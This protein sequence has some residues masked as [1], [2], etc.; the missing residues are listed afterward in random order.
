[1]KCRLVLA[2]AAFMAAAVAANIHLDPSRD[3]VR[4]RLDIP[5]Q[6][7]LDSGDNGRKS[8]ATGEPKQRQTLKR[9]WGIPDATA[10]AGQVFDLTLPRDAFEGHVSRYEVRP[11]PTFSSTTIA[12][13]RSQCA[14]GENMPSSQ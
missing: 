8:S 1:M 7:R 12:P 4:Q 14:P 10:E 11:T 13:I 9:L 2:V 5:A 6:M 3:P